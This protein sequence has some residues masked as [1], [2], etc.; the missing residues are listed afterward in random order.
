MS[1]V[2]QVSAE[3]QGWGGLSVLFQLILPLRGILNFRGS[4]KRARIKGAGVRA[5]E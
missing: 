4:P 5:L 3:G 2:D 1:G